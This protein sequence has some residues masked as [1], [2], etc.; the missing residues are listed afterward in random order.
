MTTKAPAGA[1]V[2]C[3]MASSQSIASYNGNVRNSG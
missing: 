1:F 3:R 2:V